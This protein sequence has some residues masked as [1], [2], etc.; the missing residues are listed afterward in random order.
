MSDLPRL[1]ATPPGIAVCTL[2]LLADSTARNIVIETRTGRFH[3]FLV[4]IGD[5]VR[6]YVDRCPHAG[7][8]LAQTLDAYL[9]PDRRFITCSWHGALFE[10]ETGACVGGPCAGQRLTSWPVTVRDGRIVT[11]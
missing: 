8:P 4:R 11:C 3:G 6:G 10:P 2:D 1:S 5:Q 7:L 9:T